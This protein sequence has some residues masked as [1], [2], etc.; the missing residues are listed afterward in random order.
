MQCPAP[1]LGPSHL[2]IILLQALVILAQRG[3]VDEGNH[4]LKAVDPFLAFRL[5][6]SDI[7]DPRETSPFERSGLHGP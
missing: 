6:A 4:I 3:Q 7:H 2:L 1:Y 5:L